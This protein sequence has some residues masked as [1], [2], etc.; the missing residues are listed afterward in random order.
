MDLPPIQSAVTSMARSIGVTGLTAN[1]S[2]PTVI[3][4]AR[5]MKAG[6]KSRNMI[7]TIPNIEN[8][9]RSKAST[10][11]KTTVGIE[12]STTNLIFFHSPLFSVNTLSTESSKILKELKVIN[13]NVAAIKKATILREVRDKLL[14][15]EKDISEIKKRLPPSGDIIGKPFAGYPDFDACVADNQD[16]D[17]PEGLCAHIHHQATG[18]W[19]SEKM[20]KSRVLKMSSEQLLSELAALQTRRQELSDVLFPPVSEPE[21]VAPTL[22]PEP[23]LTEERAELS[24]I[25]S[26]IRALEE[27]LG[28][29]LVEEG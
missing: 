5:R 14:N 29:A 11:T 13:S 1:P 21:T 22:E 27:A 3:G 19:P 4:K 15:V 20:M 16:A 25:E 12:V 2:V 9:Q 26:T 10:K 7:P 28:T 18:K 17:S 6:M 8:S 23:D 24:F